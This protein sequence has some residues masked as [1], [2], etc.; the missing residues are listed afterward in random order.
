[1]IPPFL[2]E[3]ASL[4]EVMSE[5]GIRDLYGKFQRKGVTV[6]VIWELTEDMLSFLELSPME[7]FRYETAKKKYAD[8]L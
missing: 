1:M 8:K 3:Q 5:A 6:D 7:K 4:S 2:S